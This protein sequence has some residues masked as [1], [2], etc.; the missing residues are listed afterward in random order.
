MSVQ[1]RK[2]GIYGLTACNRQER[3]LG[4]LGHTFGGAGL[5]DT[6]DTMEQYDDAFSF[7]AH[8][9]FAIVV[10]TPANAARSGLR[11]C[12]MSFD[13]TLNKSLV[14]RLQHKIIE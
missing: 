11:T 10:F 6:W 9:I 1:S 4:V 12:G 5:S 14:V 7:A 8:K 2:A 13:K 3:P